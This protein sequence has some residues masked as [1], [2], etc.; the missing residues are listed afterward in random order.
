MRALALCLIAVSAHAEMRRLTVE[1]AVTQLLQTQPQLVAVRERAGAT[2]DTARSQRGRL[3]PSIRLAD[4]YQ[5]FDSP[6][7]IPFQAPTMPGMKPVVINFQVRDQDTHSFTASVDQPLLG[8]GRL[9]EE[10]FARKRDSE[11]AAQGVRASEDDLKAAMRVAF[12]RCFEAR[13]SQEVALASAQQLD[14]Q[15]QV[16]QAKVN[17]GV[18]TTA[19]LLRV[20]VAADSA[21]QQAIVARSQAEI[22]RAQILSAIGLR[23]DAAVELVEPAG[24]L[25]EAA[26][27]PI[28]YDEATR[29]RPE[30]AAARAAAASA[31]HRRKASAWAMAPDIDAEGAYL[32]ID[33]SKFAPSDSG[34]VGV[35]ATW[36]LWE[37][38]ASFYALRAAE[39][40]ARAAH[41]DVETRRRGVEV[42]VASR[43]A[44]LGAATSAVKLADNTIVSAEE[45]YRVTAAQ[46]RAGAATTTDL[47]SAQAALTQARLNRSLAR[48]EEAIAKVNLAHAQGR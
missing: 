19:D 12:L 6:F 15:V 24:L 20:K 5:H 48:Y 17:A 43:S 10:Y 23:P 41:A 39:A 45:A 33:G 9:T 28:G 13:A 25:A 30:V 31:D 47:L 46:E 18:L 42:E 37:W 21:R 4:E 44:E 16:T 27:A 32:H 14:D 40:A 3:L 22:A 34:F 35:R 36:A 8:L 1:D 26:P 29:Q 2:A 7:G 11:A 38:G